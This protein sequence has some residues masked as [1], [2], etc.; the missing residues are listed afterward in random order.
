V[1]KNK[2]KSI[3]SL[4]TYKAR[5]LKVIKDYQRYGANPSKIQ[6]WNTKINKPSEPKIAKTDNQ[7]KNPDK[8]QIALSDH[9]NTPVHKIELSLRDSAKSI[10]IVPKDITSKE[11]KMLQNMLDSLISE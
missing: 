8:T 1:G 11:I 2:D 9:I 3:G 5:V 4:S 7:D 6:G 10:I